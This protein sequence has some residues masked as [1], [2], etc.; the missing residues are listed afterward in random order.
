MGGKND[1]QSLVYVFHFSLLS[2]F[3]KKSFPPP[4]EGGGG[5]YSAKYTPLTK[6]NWICLFTGSSFCG[7]YG[8]SMFTPSSSQELTDFRNWQELYK[9][10]DGKNFDIL[11]GKLVKSFQQLLNL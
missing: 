4:P 3:I 8:L 2:T 7:K 6:Y 1:D 10:I 11:L 5:G 9:S